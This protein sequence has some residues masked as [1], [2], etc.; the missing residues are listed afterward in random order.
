[1]SDSGFVAF[2]V[3]GLLVV[4]AIAIGT[5]IV[6]RM[7]QQD[8]ARVAARLGLQ[9]S[10]D[11]TFNTN[12][13]PFEL[14]G[15]GDGNGS[16]NVMWGVLEND[17]VRAVDFWYYVDSSDSEGHSSRSYHR[18]SCAIGLLPVDGPRLSI[19]HETL[20]TRAAGHLGFH[21]V[22]FESEEFNRAFRVESDDKKYAFAV[23][24]PKMMEWLLASGHPFCFE[25][26]G[27]FV[28]AYTKKLPP[29]ELPTLLRALLGFRRHV[30]AVVTSLYPAAPTGMTL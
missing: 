9:F 21:D 20:F 8:L 6:K 27:P 23:C 17:P 5:Q 3:L 11:D 7:R 25:V 14:F 4:L 16:E 1:M 15:K 30:P 2:I 12:A 24:D 13:L 28:M 18:F 10:T 19:G 22:E 26:V 29:P